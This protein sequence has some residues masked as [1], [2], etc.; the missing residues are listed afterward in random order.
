MSWRQCGRVAAMIPLK[1]ALAHQS[2]CYG[3][4]RGCHRGKGPRGQRQEHLPETRDVL[5]TRTQRKAT[6]NEP[7]CVPIGPLSPMVRRQSLVLCPSARTHQHLSALPNLPTK[8]SR[9]VGSTGDTMRMGSHHPRTIARQRRR[10]K[11]PRQTER[12]GAMMDRCLVR[13][14][15]TARDGYS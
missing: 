9:D 11:V 14:V 6:P 4:K 12:C 7:Q 1:S 2:I 10:A 3:F 5:L 15:P 8:A 13:A